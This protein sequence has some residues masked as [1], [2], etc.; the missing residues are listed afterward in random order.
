MPLETLD[1]NRNLKAIEHEY[2]VALI[3]MHR[4]ADQARH[5]PTILDRDMRVRGIG[6]A[7]SNLNGT[8]AIRLFAE[9]E[10]GL[11]KFWGATRIE[12]EPGSIA[13]IIDRIA[14]RHGIGHDELTNAHRSRLSVRGIFVQVRANSDQARGSRLRHESG[15]QLGL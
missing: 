9:F 6:E 11:R 8:Y 7:L 3:A 4:L 1:W 10:T 14:A 2:R 12:P 5:D 13:E 15:A